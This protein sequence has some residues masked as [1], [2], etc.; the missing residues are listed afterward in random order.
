MAL[1][2]QRSAED[3]GHRRGRQLPATP[4]PYRRPVRRL[5]PDG[6]P[7]GVRDRTVAIRA[8]VEKAPQQANVLRDSASMS[9]DAWAMPSSQGSPAFTGN[10]ETTGYQSDGLAQCT[11]HVL[12]VA[13]PSDK[14]GPAGSNPEIPDRVK[15][16]CRPEPPKRSINQRVG[17][18]CR[19][20]GVLSDAECAREARWECLEYCRVARDD[21]LGP[22]GLSRATP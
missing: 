21:R 17:L 2:W 13:S 5:R 15:V 20:C 22:A 19:V 9:R 12:I 18:E 16:G 6:L 3:C 14:S 1:A 10:G 4:I 11:G 8:L 7:P